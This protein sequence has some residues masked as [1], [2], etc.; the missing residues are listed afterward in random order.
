MP[1]GH[2]DQRSSFIHSFKQRKESTERRPPAR[3]PRVPLWTPPG[4]F[5]LM[6]I[7]AQPD[8][9]VQGV[10]LF[11]SRSFHRGEELLVEAPK[12]SLAPEE[13]PPPPWLSSPPQPAATV[14]TTMAAKSHFDTPGFA[15][16][17]HG[18]SSSTIDL[19]GTP[20]KP[21]WA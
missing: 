5:F 16:D 9:S 3:R 20:V 11:A 17:P 18:R 7:R 2:S 15:R 10:C 4:R 1:D 8:G 14:V 21:G 19:S 13:P 6:E 12:L